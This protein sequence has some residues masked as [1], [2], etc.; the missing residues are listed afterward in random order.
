MFRPLTRSHRRPHRRGT[1][2]VLIVV[3]MISFAAA[4]G[5]AFALFAGQSLRISQAVKDGQGGG[6][7]QLPRAPEPA[8]VVNRFL[9]SLIY[10]V[11][12]GADPATVN[13]ELTNALRGHSIARSMYG[14]DPSVGVSTIPFNGV[15]TFREGNAYG[16][17]S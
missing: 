5:V 6:G 16:D 3:V 7:L 11:G 8:S 1:S 12:D 2:F 4:V 9:G 17:R 10:D 15:G 13:E 14:R